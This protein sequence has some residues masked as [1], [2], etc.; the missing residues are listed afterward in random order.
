LLI[1]VLDPADV[2]PDIEGDALLED[3]ETGS[4]LELT[5]DAAALAAYARA[6]AALVDSLRGWARRHGG[7]YV[8]S[9]TPDDFESCV[10]RVV[11]RS[12]D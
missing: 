10:E 9:T 12:I 1:Q 3:S 4:S 2:S 7:V 8:R 6:L 5:A 11:S